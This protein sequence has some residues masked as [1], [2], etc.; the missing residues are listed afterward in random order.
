MTEKPSELK[1]WLRAVQRLIRK[2]ETRQANDEA[3]KERQA[4]TRKVVGMRAINT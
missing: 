3:D 1:E 2:A 4:E